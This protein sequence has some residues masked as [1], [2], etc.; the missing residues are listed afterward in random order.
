MNF[1]KQKHKECFLH[2]THIENIFIN[3]Y[4]P[5]A[6]GEYVK[7]FI[8]AL[9]YSVYE[10]NIKN[11]LIAKHLGMETEDVLK[12]W[13]YWEKLGAVKKTYKDKSDKFNYKIE[14]LNLKEK[15]YC[16]GSIKKA[17]EK[18]IGNSK[19]TNKGIKELYD[20][21]EDIVERFLE[22]KELQEILSWVTDYHIEPEVILF[23]YQYA[24]DRRN[25][26]KVNYV[27]KILKDWT[28]RGLY[29]IKDIET[30]LDNSDS[31]H[32]N[33]KRIMQ[34][35][36][37][38]R[39]ASEPEK[40]LI[41]SWFDE[42]KVGID[43][44]LDACGKTTGISNPNL[45]YVNTVLKGKHADGARVSGN[46]KNFKDINP[47]QKV[48]RYYEE[49]RVKKEEEAKER[50]EEVYTKIP[51][52]KELEAEL[53]DVGL[54]ISKAMIMDGA[55]RSKKIKELMVRQKKLN[56]EKAFL[57]TENNFVVDYMDI[58][59]DCNKCNDT[60]I[61]EEG[62]RCSCYEKILKSFE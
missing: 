59:Y 36:G 31:R 23:G 32:Y 20:K 39:A 61:S 48:Q 45:N 50:K 16:P 34:E 37:F 57:M 25:Q 27:G 35:L 24:K 40:K 11:E 15:M 54:D 41:D 47:I 43:E 26:T 30:F 44:I 49:L 2:D 56:S 58:K 3:E 17:K 5:G 38:M 28:Q 8:F 55:E 21:V 13:N 46:D 42:L 60:G 33:Y 6:P 62:N 19:L 7:V 18:A 10:P 12:A 52:I 29:S 22:G 4:L 1:L 53:R 14:F 51:K 9:M